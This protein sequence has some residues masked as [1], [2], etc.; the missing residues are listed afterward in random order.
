[1]AGDMFYICGVWLVY[2][3]VTNVARRYAV[4]R[5]VSSRCDGTQSQGELT[6]DY[7]NWDIRVALTFGSLPVHTDLCPIALF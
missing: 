4:R 7:I 3:F 1:M 2:S 5:Q 6:W